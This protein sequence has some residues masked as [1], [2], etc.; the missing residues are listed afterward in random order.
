LRGDLEEIL[1]EIRIAPPRSLDLAFG[2]A[3]CPPFYQEVECTR[4]LKL[5]TELPCLEKLEFDGTF[6]FHS[7]PESRMPNLKRLVF[8]HSV[9]L[10]PSPLRAFLKQTPRLEEL[11]INEIY[12]MSTSKILVESSTL[13]SLVLKTGFQVFFVNDLDLR[14]P[15]LE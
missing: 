10:R 15:N 8:H 14:V 1:R 7:G 6:G 12:H 2:T 5:L 13:T 11:I 3:A 4:L 9:K